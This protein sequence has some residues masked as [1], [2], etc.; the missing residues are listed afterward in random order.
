MLSHVVF[1]IILATLPYYAASFWGRQ[2]P[3]QLA[4]Q[5]ETRII[6]RR[7]NSH[8]WPARWL[9]QKTNECECAFRYGHKAG[10]K[11]WFLNAIVFQL[12]QV[13]PARCPS[14]SFVGCLGSPT[15]I[16]C[17]KNESV[18]TYS[19]FST[20]GPSCCLSPSMFTRISTRLVVWGVSPPI[21]MN[22]D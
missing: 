6:T 5:S 22:P 16:D 19:N 8:Q 18:P 21:V 20:G 9:Q 11:V 15:K 2:N 10:H 17:R 12:V 14:L 13:P 4:F 7:Q 3:G 1:A